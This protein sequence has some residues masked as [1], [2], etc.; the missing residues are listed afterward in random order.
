MRHIFLMISTVCCL[1]VMTTATAQEEPKQEEP[2]HELSI[3]G[4]GGYSPLSYTLSNNGTKSGGIGGGAGL[5]YTL[6][7]SPS[8]GIVAGLEMATYT[9]KASYGNIQGNYEDR[10][11]E[12]SYSLN[13]Y[14]E[15]Q[16]LTLFSI[17]IMAQYS[18]PAGSSGSIRFYASGGFKL[19]FPVSATA[20]ITPGAATTSGKPVEEGVKYDKLPQ[21]GFGEN[22]SLPATKQD[23]DLGL[24]AALA[25]ETGL[26]FNLTG[27]IGLYTGI[28]FNYGLNNI[29]KVKDKYLLEYD[30]RH[31]EEYDATNARPFLYNSVLNTGLVDE[32]NLMS[33]GL[34]LR[35]SFKL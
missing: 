29:Q 2:K 8:L 4:L 5:G 13:N 14:K 10:Y 21:H 26:R 31:L 9:S 20:D 17:P 11:L 15:V 16:N 7:I 33:I 34:K 24:S 30:V 35:V 18:I 6:N 22:I 25:L 27:K 28:Y 23:I 3:Y 19:G 12:F 1:F 32:I